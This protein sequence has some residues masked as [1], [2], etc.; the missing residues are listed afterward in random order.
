M[1]GNA[2]TEIHYFVCQLWGGG[3]TKE[4]SRKQ[5][6]E[7]RS[8]V[9]MPFV[10]AP[11]SESCENGWRRSILVLGVACHANK[12]SR[13]S[14]GPT[15]LICVERMSMPSCSQSHTNSIDSFFKYKCSITKLIYI[16]LKIFLNL[17][18]S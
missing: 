1:Y 7:T 6:Q 3:L 16:H 9:V 13:V 15:P 14:K 18:P 17:K 11:P 4:V 5:A 12:P 2:I 10:S 8:T